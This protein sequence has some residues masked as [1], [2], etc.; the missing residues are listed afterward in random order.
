MRAAISTVSR[1]AEPAEFG[2][3]GMRVWQGR[4]KIVRQFSGIGKVFRNKL[5]LGGRSP[6]SVPPKLQYCFTNADTGMTVF[7]PFRFV[8]R[9][10]Y[11]EGIDLR[12]YTTSLNAAIYQLFQAAGLHERNEF[13]LK[14]LV[15]IN[16]EEAAQAGRRPLPLWDFSDANTIT[17]DPVPLSTDPTPMRWYW[18]HSHYRKATGDLILDRVFGYSDPKRLIPADFGVQ[19]TSANVDQHIARAKAGLQAWAAA[20]SELVEPIVRAGRTLKTHS[21][22]PEATCW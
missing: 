1:Q 4:E 21:R 6:W 14:E 19:L 11:A 13:W 7:D 18:E 3:A 15:R 10:A 8:P 12:L 16:E 17:R 2:D 9:H 20:N 5:A 22:Q